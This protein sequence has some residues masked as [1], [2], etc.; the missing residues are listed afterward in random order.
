M[1]ES[2]DQHI[3]DGILEEN[4]QILKDLY[5]DYYPG[6]QRFILSR[7]GTIED[8]RDIFQDSL[9]VIYL[10]A[11]K[12][13]DFLR[14]RFENFLLSVCKILWLKQQ[15]KAY[16]YGFNISSWVEEFT[17][18]DHQIIDDMILM[19]KQKLVWKH[20]KQLGKECQQILQLSFDETP[21]ELIKEILGFSSVQYT[22]NR[23]TNCK[24]ILVRRIWNSPE[25]K[26]LRNEKLRENTTVPRW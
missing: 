26:E 23:K 7:K 11:R 10:R 9:V 4:S 21:L 5:K 18:F 17:D 3:I 6:V 24:S 2:G 16:A 15:R 19:E 1:K 22:K 13:P 20:F 8:A 12:E 25:Y 14:T